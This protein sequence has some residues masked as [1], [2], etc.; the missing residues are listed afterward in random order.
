M[1]YLLYRVISICQ[2]VS[3]VLLP[4]KHIPIS[5]S[6]FLLLTSFPS[7][8]LSRGCCLH[9]LLPNTGILPWWLLFL[10]YW[11]AFAIPGARCI[12]WKYSTGTTCSTTSQ[13]LIS[14]AAGNL[15]RIQS[16]YN[17]GVPVVH[18]GTYKYGTGTRVDT[19]GLAFSTY[20]EDISPRFLVLLAFVQF[21]C[22]FGYSGVTFS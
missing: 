20:P 10:Y 1:E 12:C 4:P 6:S 3:V 5:S 17:N 9:P 15:S 11:L 19:L 21:S 18:W 22:P 14:Y 13:V 16:A 8:P 7:F 2:R